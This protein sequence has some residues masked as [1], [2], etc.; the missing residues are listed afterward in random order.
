MKENPTWH[1][2]DSAWKAGQILRMLE[3]NRVMPKTV[4]EVGCGAGEV[5]RQLQERMDRSCEFLGYEVSPQAFRLCQERANDRLHFKL[6]DFLQEE[7]NCF[8]L[9]LLIDVIEHLDDY[10]GFLRK[11]R[12]R[13]RYKILHIPLDLSVQSILRP[14]MLTELKRTKGHLHYFARET[15]ME[16][17]AQAG[18]EIVDYFL[19]PVALEAVHK[20]IKTHVANVPRRIASIVSRNLAARL[21]GG[22]SLMVLA[23]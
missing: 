21:F 17:L 19:T 22:F 11:V 6:Q 12:S 9:L 15:A 14:S 18:Y 3:R 4:C 5:L 10:L 13:S 23:T 20:T 1:V 8:D 2:E 16:S 7:G